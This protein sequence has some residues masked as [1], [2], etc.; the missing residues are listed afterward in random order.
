MTTCS[1]PHCKATSK[2]GRHPPGP[3]PNPTY[4]HRPREGAQP[5]PPPAALSPA[6]RQAA[7]TGYHGIPSLRHGALHR[8]HMV[9]KRAK[10]SLHPSRGSP[11]PD[12]FL[13]CP[14]PLLPPHLSPPSC[15][16][17]SSFYSFAWASLRTPGGP[18]SPVSLP[19]FPVPLQGFPPPLP[20][21]PLGLRR[22]I[23]Q[24]LRPHTQH[25]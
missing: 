17:S 25:E 19:Q 18:R 12:A 15:P 24:G 20:P 14:P 21:P 9:R 6:P 7:H 2:W 8:E 13:H 23:R 3:A 16:S 10:A 11:F 1:S 22:V 5:Q 4:L